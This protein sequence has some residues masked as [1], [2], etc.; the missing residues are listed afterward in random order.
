MR[1]WVSTANA[2]DSA[3]GD[4]AAVCKSAC[5]SI[6]QGEMSPIGRGTLAALQMRDTLRR[7]DPTC[8]FL[9][10]RDLRGLSRIRMRAEARRGVL[11]RLEGHRR[12]RPE[13][14]QLKLRLTGWDP[15]QASGQV[16]RSFHRSDAFDYA[17]WVN[18]HAPAGGACNGTERAAARYTSEGDRRYAPSVAHG[19]QSRDDLSVWRGAPGARRCP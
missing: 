19:V 13:A 11:G 15:T 14:Q 7:A 6:S 17:G 18:V 5:A 9:V 8:R 10:R 2:A 3:R 16:R 1:P 12:D 4:L